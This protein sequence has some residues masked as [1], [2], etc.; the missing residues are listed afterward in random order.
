MD[1]RI[2]I[3]WVLV[4][5]SQRCHALLL[6]IG[7]E[8]IESCSGIEANWIQDSLYFWWYLRRC[9]M[10]ICKDVSC[11]TLHLASLMILMTNH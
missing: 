9:R 5:S 4:V 2:S 11:E 7:F 1:R 6:L 8:R 3:R 10:L